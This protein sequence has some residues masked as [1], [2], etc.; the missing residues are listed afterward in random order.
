MSMK[1]GGVLSSKDMLFKWIWYCLC[2]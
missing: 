1:L 2:V